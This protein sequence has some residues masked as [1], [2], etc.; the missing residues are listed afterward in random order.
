MPPRAGPRRADQ[1]LDE[2][3]VALG[4][5]HDVAHALLG[6]RVGVE[7]RDQAAYVG[8]V[9]RLELDPLDA[10]HP[11][12]HGDL[13]TEGVTAVQV[14][15]PVGADEGHRRLEAA[16]E[17]E[18]DQVARRLVGPVEVLHDQ[19]Q[20]LAGAGRLGQRVD[21]VEQ[22]GLVG[23]DRL[24]VGGL[25]QHPLAGQ[26]TE[27][28]GMAGRDVVEEV[29]Q[30]AGDPAGDLRERK[31]GKGRVGEVEAV[32]GEDLPAAVDGP[33]AELGEEPGLADTGV[34][35]EQDR[36]ALGGRG[37]AGRGDA[38]RGAQVLQLGISSDQLRRHA[39][40]DVVD[41]GRHLS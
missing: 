4:P 14:V 28:G 33:V 35:G 15:G 29:G 22:G 30:V 23:R 19:E 24:G 34:A 17:Q 38:E 11:G 7:A 12:P 6:Q 10:G 26:Q 41:H 1:L 31:V 32:A 5:G 20:R 40:H 16:A 13:A 3:R 39:V 18:A 25:A 9:E 37:R 21:A 8:G 2:E 27:Q 36:G